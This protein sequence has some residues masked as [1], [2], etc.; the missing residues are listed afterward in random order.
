MGTTVY[1]S[2][3]YQDQI[4]GSLQSAREVVSIVLS[5]VRPQSVVD[6]GC[7]M[8]TWLSAFREHEIQDVIGLDGDYVN[9]K[10]LL[11]PENLF[12]PHDLTKRIELEREFDLVMSLEVAEHLSSEFAKNFVKGLVSLG[13]VVLFS[14]A[15]PGQGG[16][17]HVNEQWP[18]YWRDL[19]AE[20]GYVAVDCLRTRIWNNRKVQVC[21]RQNIMFYVEE[22]YLQNSPLLLKEKEKS[23]DR[24]FSV[25]HPD[26]LQECLTRPPTLRPLLKAL[27]HALSESFKQRTSKTEK[28]S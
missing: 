11:I 25:V 17:H 2:D 10:N 14:A 23:D 19:F 13:K 24:I 20:Q 22:K 28:D 18:E 9:R 16:T 6:V 1:D 3:F 7:G 8:G 4:S 12:I 15:I 27:P 26:M 5:M 21:Y